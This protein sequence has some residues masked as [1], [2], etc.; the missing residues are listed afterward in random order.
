MR[1]LNYVGRDAANCNLRLAAYFAVPHASSK[2]THL[3]QTR[4]WQFGDRRL[5]LV[6]PLLSLAA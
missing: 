2:P 3:Q 1:D 6:Y 5:E 4:A